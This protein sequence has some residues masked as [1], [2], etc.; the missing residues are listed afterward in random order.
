[1]NAWPG[2]P[3]I[4]AVALRKDTDQTP[5]KEILEHLYTLDPYSVT[6]V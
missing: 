6:A 1:M 3:K 2:E 4:L 5:E